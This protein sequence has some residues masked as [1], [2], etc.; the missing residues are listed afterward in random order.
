MK[1]ITKRVAS[2]FIFEWVFVFTCH[3][4]QYATQNN[5]LAN[6]VQTMGAN[7]HLIGNT[8]N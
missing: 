4:F 6:C 1:L 2:D 5:N 8:E 7:E 3:Y